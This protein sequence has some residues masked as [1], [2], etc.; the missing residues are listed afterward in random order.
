MG[1][2]S[3]AKEIVYVNNISD[4]PI[5]SIEINNSRNED[6]NDINSIKGRIRTPSDKK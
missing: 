2:C 4:I 5:N 1:I 6:K 3:K